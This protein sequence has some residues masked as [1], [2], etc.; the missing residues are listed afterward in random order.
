M[1]RARQ[2]LA[3]SLRTVRRAAPDGPLVPALTE[4]GRW[5]EE[6]HPRS[7]VELDYGGLVHTISAEALAVDHSAAEVAEALAALAADDLERA[8]ELYEALTE[9][10]TSVRERQFAS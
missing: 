5:M 9:R 6:F 7:M 10:W 8:G 1:V 2:R 4:V 3:R